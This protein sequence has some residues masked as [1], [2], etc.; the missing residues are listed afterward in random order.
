MLEGIERNEIIAGAYTDDGGVCPILAAHRAGGRGGS[1]AFAHAWDRFAFRE[2]P[3]RFWM[4]LSRSRAARRATARELL[5]LRAHLEASLL[6]EEVPAAELA[7]AAADHRR[8]VA[9]RDVAAGSRPDRAGHTSARRSEPKPSLS[10]G[11]RAERA[12]VN[13]RARSGRRS[14]RPA[15]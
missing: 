9:A 10:V 8:L 2:A 1:I 13:T 6:D 7:A 15:S 12:C 14:M 5:V 3:R 11:R 4:R